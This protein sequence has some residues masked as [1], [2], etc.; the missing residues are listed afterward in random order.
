[1]KKILF[2]LALAVAAIN[3]LANT[4]AAG[5]TIYAQNNLE[6]NEPS[7]EIV[8]IDTIYNAEEIV[9]PEQY[10]QYQAVCEKVDRK[11]ERL[12]R[13]SLPKILKRHISKK[14]P[15]MGLCH[16]VWYYKK[17][18]LKEEYNIDW[19][20]PQDLCPECFFD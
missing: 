11:A 20:S 15:I 16:T 12:A 8:T 3:I 7:P 10:E 19:K 14:M 13:R 6:S 2:V 9:P 4:P 18:I 17:K 5:D 1:M